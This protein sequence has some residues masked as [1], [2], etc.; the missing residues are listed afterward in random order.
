M[1]QISIYSTI[2]EKVEEFSISE[3][4][5]N[6]KPNYHLLHEIIV[7]YQA[8]QRQGTVSTKT[9]G[10]VAGS[11][12]K[13]WRQKGTGRARVGS[14][15]TPLWRKGGVI[16]GPKPR[17]FHY[18]ISKKKKRKAFKIALASK[19]QEGKIIVL[20]EFNLPQMKTKEMVKILNLLKIKTSVLIILDKKNEIIENA[21]RNIKNINTELLEYLNTYE[22]LKYENLL[23]SKEVLVKLLEIFK[24]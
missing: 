16:F 15:R 18:K 5:F 9:R 6:I 10:E 13:P 24:N 20:K 17:D 22:V 19:F 14:K 1:P 8:N 3:D 12:V 21:S 7:N 11:G 2:G 23:L 4:I